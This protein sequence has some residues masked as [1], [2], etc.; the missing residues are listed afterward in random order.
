MEDL[1]EGKWERGTK[2]KGG[3]REEEQRHSAIEIGTRIRKE[4]GWK[5]NGRE[6]VN[7]QEK[8]GFEKMAMECK[9]CVVDERTKE[10]EK[11]GYCA[12]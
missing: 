6:E 2:K 7:L 12:F 11:R 1:R 4:D 10:R 3:L 9:V 8:V 5:T